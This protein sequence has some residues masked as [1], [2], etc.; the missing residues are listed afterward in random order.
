MRV[1]LV[2]HGYPPAAQGGSEIYAAA[3]AKSLVRDHGDDVV[4]LTRSNEPDRP[5]YEVRESADDGVRVVRINNTFRDTTSVSDSYVHPRIAA[6]AAPFIAVFRP[7]VAYIHHLTC[8]STLIPELLAAAHVPAFMTLHDY[9]LLCHRGQLFDT[10]HRMCANAGRQCDRCIQGAAAAGV[11]GR[12]LPLLRR[13]ARL[14]PAAARAN[15]EHACAS[16]HSRVDDHTGDGRRLRDASFSVEQSALR[17]EHMRSVANH[18]THFFAPSAHIR[19]VFIESGLVTRDRITLSPYG[20]DRSAGSPRTALTETCGA[21][22]VGTDVRRTGELPHGLTPGASGSAR[23]RADDI[24][25]AG[26]VVGDRNRPLQIGYVGSLMVSKAPHVLVEA[27]GM[28]PPGLAHVHLFGEVVPYHGDDSYRRRVEGFADVAPV[29]RHP[30]RP[31]AA[32]LD[33]YRALDV[34]VVPS[35]W[36]E[37][38]PLVIHEALA[39]G[40]P[41]VASDVGGIPELVTHERNGLLFPPGDASALAAAL[42]RLA[43]EPQLLPTLKAHIEC[44]RPLAGDVGSMRRFAT[45]AA[46]S[47][48]PAN[49]CSVH[50]VVVNFHTPD[51]TLLAVRSLLASRHPFTR[52]VVV[53]NSHD[54]ACESALTGL[55]DH[56]DYVSAGTNRGF[57]GGMNIGVT[58]ALAAGATHVLLVNSDAIVP[59]DCLGGLLRSFAQPSVGIVSPTVLSLGSPDRI[60]SMGASYNLRTGR[61]RIRRHG[62]PASE[63]FSHAGE[64]DA[65]SG[66]VMLVSRAVFKTIGMLDEEYFFGFEE[67]EFSLRARQRGFSVNVTSDVAFHEG[68]CSLSSASTRLY[69][70]ARNHL[71]MAARVQTPSAPRALAVIALNIASALRSQPVNIPSRLVAVTRGTLHH[72]RGRYGAA[73]LNDGRERKR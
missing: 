68:G 61:M 6:I 45:Q 4:V 25:A 42:L 71:R 43:R 54:R 69:Y 37:N 13:A 2:I 5:E 1:L 30:Q 72:F 17:L 50:A 28:L 29:H 65:A 59:P 40:I 70:A 26:A 67:I 35:V 20:V 44:P 62:A 31:N 16:G 36:A 49:A 56:V 73:T 34:L 32:M 57:A 63:R 27:A 38:S 24:A 8:L 47:V 46:T 23:E 22:K 53:D 3:H 48:Q 39:F 60:Q 12:T 66:C 18:I 58:R 41:V 51:A 14:L 7:D 19:Q 9:W 15:I 52:I 55:P 10:S 11:R 64:V 21:E 33:T